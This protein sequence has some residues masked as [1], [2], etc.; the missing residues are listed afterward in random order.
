[1]Y[2]FSK[3]AVYIAIAILLLAGGAVFYLNLKKQGK[4]AV[5][6][7]VGEK[8]SIMDQE[9]SHSSEETVDN[10]NDSV[11]ES[12]SAGIEQDADVSS[13]IS[14]SSS[15]SSSS[16]KNQGEDDSSDSNADAPEFKIINKLVRFG[17]QKSSGRSIDT[18]VVHSSYDAIG[19]DPY[20]VSGLIAEYKSY[21]VSPHYL[22]DRKGNVYR[23]V[24]DQNIAYHAG[25]SKMPDGRTGVNNFSIGV[26]IMTTKTEKPTSAQY[27]SLNGLI[28][29][30]KGK[31][32]L[33]YIL[34]HDDIAPGRKDD[35]WNFD[36]GKVD[37]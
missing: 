5:S 29:Y 2:L 8:K 27:G 16:V 37:K 31:Y 6:S 19:S 17:F 22:I 12:S 4:A 11:S 14:S 28:D 26:E 25:D 24:E 13:S 35:P 18:L 3:K 1:M 20:S 10:A 30:L 23:L 36:W 34:G 32:K 21:G 15:S 33:K 9:A 7:I